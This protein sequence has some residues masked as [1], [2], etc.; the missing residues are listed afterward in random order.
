MRQMARHFRSDLH[1]RRTHDFLVRLSAHV[2]GASLQ[3]RVHLRFSTGRP[4]LLAAVQSCIRGEPFLPR[5]GIA[6]LQTPSSGL[7]YLRKDSV[8][9][10]ILHAV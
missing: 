7:L 2:A 10:I 9:A 8:L 5:D 4:R 1:S 3:F 6:S